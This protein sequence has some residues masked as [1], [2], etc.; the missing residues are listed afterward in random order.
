MKKIALPFCVSLILNFDFVNAAW[1][2]K[3]KYIC[4][5]LIFC[6][7]QFSIFNSLMAQDSNKVSIKPYG[8]IRNYFN[9]DSRKTYTV[10]GG[11]YNMIPYDEKWNE[12]HSEDLNAVPHAQLQALTSRFGIDVSGLQIG[13]WAT[14]AKLEGDFGGFGTTNSVLRL[15]LAYLKL[16]RE[17]AR[18][19]KEL[20]IGQEWHPLS[21]DIM[22][23][24]LGMAAGAPF[25]PHS[26]TPQ[27]RATSYWGKLGVTASLLYQLQYMNN[28]PKAANDPSSVASLDYAYNAIW[29]E[30][31]IGLNF[32]SSRLYAQLGVD[33]QILRPRT[34]AVIGGITKKVDETIESLTPTVCAQYTGNK[35]SVKFRG[36]LAQNTSHLNQLCGYAVTG[37]ND[38]GSWSYAPIRNYVSFLNISYG[39]KY[40]ANLFLGYIK[41]LGATEDLHDFGTPGNPSYMIYMKGGQDFTGL[42]SIYRI[43]PS[44]SYNVKAFNL[45]IEYELTACTYGD[46]ATDGSIHNNDNLHQVVNRRICAMVKYNF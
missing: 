1:L 11:E 27:V 17:K 39:K 3:S 9:Y 5:L 29:P 46:I 42:N 21:G 23:D 44:I 33:A 28:G 41:N 13:K 2:R 40:R 43:A 36:L 19:K 15:R 24:V 35:L 31:F 4:F 16:K 12:D 7:S 8:F 38:D 25:R 14:N 20:L 6:C 37:I 10:I 45:G 32:K 18:N 34:H 30:A 22:P 26:R